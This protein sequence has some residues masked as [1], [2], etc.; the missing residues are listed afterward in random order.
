MKPKIATVRLNREEQ[1]LLQL[2]MNMSERIKRQGLSTSDVF[3]EALLLQF[4]TLKSQYPDVWAKV[5]N[6]PLK[7]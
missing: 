4:N 6:E 2:V 1:I 7:F 5:K 3:K